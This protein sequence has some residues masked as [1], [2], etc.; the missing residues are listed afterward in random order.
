MQR[1]EVEG[2]GHEMEGEENG[3]NEGSRESI[4]KKGPRRD[5]RGG[6]DMRAETHSPRI[7][8]RFNFLEREI[9]S[10]YSP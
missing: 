1:K 9:R 8:T 4:R 5:P 10:E 6:R 7:H 2:R 3:G